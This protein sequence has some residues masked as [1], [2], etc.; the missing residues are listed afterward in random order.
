MSS[1]IIFTSSTIPQ[2][3]ELLIIREELSEL[4]GIPVSLIEVGINSIAANG[5]GGF[6]LTLD[7]AV[8]SEDSEVV[9]SAHN[10]MKN[11]SI[12][13]NLLDSLHGR[14]MM[15]FTE[16][17]MGA[18]QR[19]STSNPENTDKDLPMSYF[20]YAGSGAAVVVLCLL[21]YIVHTK[22]SKQTRRNTALSISQTHLLMSSR[23]STSRLL[24]SQVFLGDDTG[25]GSSSGSE[26][27]IFSNPMH[28]RQSVANPMYDQ[29]TL[30]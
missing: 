23:Q 8:E 13:D 7:V 2:E 4:L 1:E 5:A 9:S 18:V 30:V 12:G 29:V 14:D 19:T 3:G 28:H 25:S 6:S 24:S 21:A 10:G 11:E 17:R 15:G 20:I 27:E 22:R 16:A 26:A